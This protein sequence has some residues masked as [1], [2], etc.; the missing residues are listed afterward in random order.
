MSNAEF[1]FPKFADE[2]T[3]H[4]LYAIWNGWRGEKLFPSRAD[5]DLKAL[6]SHMEGVILFEV[7][8]RKNIIIRY[9]GSMIMDFY[10]SDY[11]GRNFLD[12]TDANVKELRSK[13]MLGVVEQPCGAVWTTR[14]ISY[15]AER[16]FSVGVSLPIA[17]RAGEAPSQILQVCLP[18]RGTERP[19]FER[20]APT[21][22]QLSDRYAFVDIGAGLADQSVVTE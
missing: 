20:K 19:A 8:D 4:R 11:T 9:F 17:A 5:V 14:G 13:R 15:G 18:F 6:S 1:R 12:L 2:E 3:I 10:G 21:N 22:V 7:Q 16:S